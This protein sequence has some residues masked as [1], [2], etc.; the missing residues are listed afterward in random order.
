MRRAVFAIIG[1]ELA[2]MLR[3]RGRLVAA[4][5]RPLIWL[6]VIG[7]GFQ[8]LLAGLGADDY[9]RFMVPGLLSMVLLFGAMLAS[10]SLVYDK[11]SGVMRMLVIAPFPHY[12]IVLARTLSA[13]IAGLAQA[14]MLMVLL[15]ALGFLSLPASPALLVLALVMTAIT[16]AATGMLIAVFSKTLDNFAVIMNFVIFP[17]FFL[18]GA[19]YPLAHLPAALKTLALANPFSYGVD[20]MKH[21][22]LGGGGGRFGPDIPVATDVAV[23]LAFTAVALAVACLRFSRAPVIER[24]AQALSKPRR[25]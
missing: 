1:R 18:S 8:A 20:L 5:V 17:M 11:E 9:K 13:A 23:M 2:R 12:A 21:G 15:A 7:G 16:C 25:G 19:L 14:A 4:M 3:Q 6:F 24:L 22:I 10:L